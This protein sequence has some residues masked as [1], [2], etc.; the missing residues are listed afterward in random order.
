M[1]GK[2]KIEPLADHKKFLPPL[3]VLFEIEWPFYYG[4]NG[5]GNAQMDLKE[6]AKKK[7]LPYG[8]IAILDGKLCGTA[9]LKN[10]SIFTHPHLHPWA[11]AG[12]VV[13]AYRKQGI[14]SKLL[15]ALENVAKEIGSSHIYCGTNTANNILLQRSWQFLEWAI[16][17]G[18]KVGIYQKKL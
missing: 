18:E 6:Y 10:K 16:Q 9:V 12:I 3:Q 11:A 7:G 17:N 14:G 5:P 15:A 2:L 13:P 4:T 8:V 1:I